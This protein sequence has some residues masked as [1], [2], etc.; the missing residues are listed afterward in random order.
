MILS[1][2]KKTAFLLVVVGACNSL[3][4]V[5]LP[6]HFSVTGQVF[7]E[8]DAPIE[9][10]EIILLDSA[11]DRA[12]ELALYG[13]GVPIARSG[14]EGSYTVPQLVPGKY[15][16]AVLSEGK[17]SSK[18]KISIVDRDVTQN[19]VLYDL[20]DELEEITIDAGNQSVLGIHRL[21]AVEKDALYD[22]KKNEVVILDD[23]TANLATNNSRQIYARVPGLNIWESD[24]AG[25]QIGIG[26][27]GLSPNRNSNFNTRQNGYDIAADALGYPESY[28]SPPVMALEQIQIVR[29][30][31]SLQYGTQFGG[32]L[33]FVFKDG[34]EYK[35]VDV[36]A[37]QTVGSF[38]LY[39]SFNSVGGTAG[40]IRY[41][42]FYQYKHNNGWRP[43][44]ELSQHTA[45]AGITYQ[46]SDRWS[47]KPEFTYMTYLAQQPGGLTDAQFEADPRQSSRD[48]N[49]FNVDWYLWALASDYVFSSRTRLN[50]RFFGLFAGRDALGNLSRI[51]R[52]DFGG[53]RDLISDRFKNWGNETRL[54]HRYS[55]W[56]D[57]SVLLVGSRF[58][59]GFTDRT[60]GEGNDGEGPDFDYLNPE[61]LEGSDFELPS[62]NASLFVEN[63]FNIG[64]RLSVIPGVRFEYIDTRADGYYRNIVRDLA[65]N[66]LTDQ[67]IEETR[68][69]TRSFAFFGVGLSFKQSN[70][71]EVY[72]NFSQNYRAINFNDIR[73]NV[74]S[75]EVDPDIKDER[76]YNVELGIRGLMTEVV[77]F[78]ISLFHLSY[79]DRIGTVLKTAPNPQFNNL[80]N[81]IF[82]YR[83]NVADA[84]IYGVEG[85]AELD[86]L[87][88]L[89]DPKNHTRLSVFG[90]VAWIHARYTDSDENGI[91]GNEVEMVPGI[92][93]KVGAVLR[94]DV[95]RVAYQL[96]YVGEH[97][98]D[99][100]NA[101][102]TPT[103]IEGIIPSYRIMDLSI[104]AR[105][106]R[107]RLD[108]GV[109]NLTNTSYFTRRAT[110]YPGPGIIPS[111]GRSIY[112]TAGIQI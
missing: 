71:L 29:G 100:S 61:L 105:M 77:N 55:L 98:S 108:A 93:L 73:V 16:L 66:I 26:G 20:E 13:L 102:R 97:F 67:R 62:S 43:N 106:G 10:A 30:A 5:A 17:Q 81:R 28:Y 50:T 54:V 99:A 82:R 65:G 92:N 96:G 27:R 47:L 112:I 107:Y 57:M 94:T 42:S 53:N 44:E 79:Q 83:T 1:L 80:V 58:Y 46:F 51:D 19:V 63:I 64:P 49:W 111:T 36:T 18:Q 104:Q 48:R 15:V 109:N 41:Y 37:L 76:G 69:S 25:V 68:K 7:D 101:I 59:R 78:D 33:N 88:L 110:G 11:L 45:Y 22:G 86:V 52:L 70:A 91:T 14:W 12:D 9:N 23:I 35:A 39:N 84:E 72:S 74:G 40:N 6:Q 89:V 24:G 103:A 60:Q 90:N 4:N 85:Y 3:F 95:F 8:R 56:N 87:K 38:G 32:L 2:L 21:R 75:L 31:A 34:H